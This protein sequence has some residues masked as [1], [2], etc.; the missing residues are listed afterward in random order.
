MF[1]SNTIEVFIPNSIKQNKT[2]KTYNVVAV[3]V[4]WLL[5]LIEI[6]T[7]YWVQLCRLHNRC[8][9]KNIKRYT[10]PKI[11]LLVMAVSHISTEQWISARLGFSSRVQLRPN[12]LS[13][14][15][16]ITI[17]V[18]NYGLFSI[19]VDN[20]HYDNEQTILLNLKSFTIQTIEKFNFTS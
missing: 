17:V 8:I 5:K 2:K 10:I 18:H 11:F 15:V 4:L 7:M 20:V 6:I 3:I 19:I 13:S 14:S 1:N 16:H 9:Y 12:S